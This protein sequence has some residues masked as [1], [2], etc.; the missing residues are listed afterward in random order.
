M[1]AAQRLSSGKKMERVRR[2]SSR[3]VSEIVKKNNN[4]EY[5]RNTENQ[6]GRKKK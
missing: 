6:N 1:M 2:K 5:L 3:K 4:P